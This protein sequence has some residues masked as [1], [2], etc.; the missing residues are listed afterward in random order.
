[1]TI[2]KSAADVNIDGFLNTTDVVRIRRFVADGCKYDVN[3]YGI[4]L[5]FNKPVCTHTMEHIPSKLPTCTDPGDVEYYHCTTCG[6]NYN[7]SKGTNEITPF[8]VVP[9]AGHKIVTHAAQEPTYDSE[10]WYEW[11]DC[12]VCG[13][14]LVEKVMI[15]KLEKTTVT[16][17]YHY[18]GL[19]QDSYLSSYI[20]KNNVAAFNPNSLEYNTAEKGYALSALLSNAVPGYKFLGWVDGYGN[21]VTSIAKGDEGHLDLYASWKKID[22]WVTFK[23]PDVPA[24]NIPAY[25]YSD[26]SVPANSVRYTVDIGL[27]LTDYNPSWYGYTFVGWSNSDGFLITEIEPGTTG[28]ITVQ[29]NWTSNR[30]KATSYPSYGE[31]I[32]IEDAENGQ[33]LFVYNIGKIENVPLNEVKGSYFHNMDIKTFSEELS[34][35]NS[36][37][38][39]FVNTINE[40]VSNATTKSSGWTLSNEWNDLYSIITD[41]LAAWNP[42]C[43]R[44]DYY[45]SYYSDYYKMFQ[46]RKVEE[47]ESGTLVEEGNGIS[48]VQAWV[49]YRE[50]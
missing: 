45:T 9:A 47:L 46:Y 42:R 22:Y 3:G 15:P 30:N 33:F 26:T 17:T 28:N 24:T 19:E 10:G 37:D 35:T 43:F 16:V 20:V 23:S 4:K 1:M 44:F 8:G 50:R 21:A 25:D 40:M 32:I 5:L 12:S 27:N 29:A 18:E 48:N 49:K 34:V 13:E 11:K 31:P 36:V 2:I 6:K 39:G 41:T 38:E 7:D 14:V